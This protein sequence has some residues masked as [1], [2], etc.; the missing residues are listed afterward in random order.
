MSAMSCLVSLAVLICCSN[1]FVFDICYAQSHAIEEYQT[2]FEHRKKMC[3]ICG[4]HFHPQAFTGHFKKCKRE[5]EE[6]EGQ[7]LYEKDMLDW[8]QALLA[9]NITIHHSFGI[10]CLHLNPQAPSS[11]RAAIGVLTAC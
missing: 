1:F 9:G 7:L 11:S 8:A 10:P 6:T 2:V 5:K 4:S 3:S